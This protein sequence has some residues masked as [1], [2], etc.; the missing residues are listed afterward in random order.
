MREH[1]VAGSR[2]LFALATFLF[3]ASLYLF[4]P[5][6]P[7]YAESLGASLTMVGVVIG[8]YGIAQLLL[9]VPIG[10]VADAYGQRKLLAQGGIVAACLGALL[11]WLA[12][13]LDRAGYPDHAARLNPVTVTQAVEELEA[14]A[15]QVRA[16]HPH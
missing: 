2:T 7:V 13:M 8:S 6:L 3:W 11:M 14:V 16:A 12:P 10:L 9:R 1:P 4:V 15:L 5:I